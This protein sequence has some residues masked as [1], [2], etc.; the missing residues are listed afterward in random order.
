MTNYVSKILKLAMLYIAFII[1]L[2]LPGILIR[3]TNE[4]LLETYNIRYKLQTRFIP[5]DMNTWKQRGAIKV[6]SIWFSV[7]ATKLMIVFASAIDLACG[8]T[9]ESI[10]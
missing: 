4:M 8:G 2:I 6:A 7:D 5:I 3:S 10:L 9:R 1:K